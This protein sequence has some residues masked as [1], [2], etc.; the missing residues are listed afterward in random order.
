VFLDAARVRAPGA[1]DSG[2]RRNVGLGL[3][4][5][6]PRAAL[7][8]VAR[9]DVAWSLGGARERS[10]PVLSFGSSQAF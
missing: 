1:G 7:H 2:L 3:R 5:S 8:R 6:L 10:G 9:L 4:L